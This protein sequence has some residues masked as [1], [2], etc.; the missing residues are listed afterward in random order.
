MA[1]KN[2]VRP[3]PRSHSRKAL[4][5][6]EILKILKIASES[7]RNLAMIVLAYRHGMRASE[8]C[9][10]RLSGVDMKSGEVTIRRL[11]RSANRPT[12]FG[13]SGATAFLRETGFAGVAGGTTRRQRF[14]IHFT[15]RRTDSP[16]AIL[17]V[18]QSIAERAGLPPDR[19]HPIA[20]STRSH[21][22][23]VAGHVHLI[24]SETGSRAPEHRFHGHLRG[25]HGRTDRQGGQ[26]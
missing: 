17:R 7:K 25:S 10:L 15:K 22:H 11:K 18:F 3:I 6:Q 24:N 20:S 14:H 26:F 1:T 21:S 9:D 8:V 23:F 4:T 12:A 13:A 16:H 19:R 2:L 5:P